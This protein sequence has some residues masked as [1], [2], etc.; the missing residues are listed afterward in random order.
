[1][2]F[3]TL[4]LVGVAVAAP[5]T[6]VDLGSLLVGLTGGT[7]GAGGLGGLD[8]N[9]LAGAFLGGGSGPTGDVNVILTQYGNI[10]EK[11]EAQ[12]AFVKGL[13][14]KAPADLIA[15]LDKFGADQVEALKAAAKAVDGMAGPLD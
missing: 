15:K 11:V 14:D 3:T 12:D 5:V 9:A 10:K 7:G 4:A 2:R 13:V 1:M 6:Q 8:L